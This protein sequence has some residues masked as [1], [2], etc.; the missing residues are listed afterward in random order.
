MEFKR[1]LHRFMMEVSRIETLAG[2]KRTV[3]NPYDSFVRPLAAWLQK[4]GVQVMTGCRV[5]D[6]AIDLDLG[7][8]FANANRIPCRMPCITRSRRSS[9][10]CD[11]SIEASIDAASAQLGAVLDDARHQPV[12]HGFLR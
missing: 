12:G 11:A 4:Q 8:P 10:R 2:V 3:Y 5:T 7:E 9:R 6:L 1:Y